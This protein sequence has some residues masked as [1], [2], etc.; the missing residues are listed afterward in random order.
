MSD[1]IWE[2]SEAVIDSI[3][4]RR[5]VSVALFSRSNVTLVAEFDWRMPLNMRPSVDHTS[6]RRTDLVSLLPDP[7]TRQTVFRECI[8]TALRVALR[9]EGLLIPIEAL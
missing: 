6:Q 3:S 4:A 2:T 9:S 8:A 7:V 1:G 5:I